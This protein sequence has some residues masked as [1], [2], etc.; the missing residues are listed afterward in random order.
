MIFFFLR[1]HIKFFSK[2]YQVVIFT[3][4]NDTND[5]LKFLPSKVK[6]VDIPFRRKINLFYDLFS[7]IKL[8]SNVYQNEFDIIYSISPKA[9]FLSMVAGKMVGVPIRINNFTGQQ[10]VIK[11][12]FQRQI[13]K[14]VDSATAKLATLNL[15]DGKS[16]QQFLIKNNIINKINSKVIKHGSICGVNLKQFLPNKKH[17]DLTRKKLGIPKKDIVFIYLGRVNKDKG[18]DKIA[19]AITNL[20]KQKFSVSL[21][22]VGP[23]EDPVLDGVAKIFNCYKDCLNVVPFTS[24]PE[25]Y[26]Q[27]SDVFCTLSNKEGFGNSI[28]E[29]GACGLPSIGSNIY[30]LKDSILHNKTG[31]LVDRSDQKKINYYFKKIVKNKNNMIKMGMNAKLRTIKYFDQDIIS[32]ELMETIKDL[33]NKI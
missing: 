3:K 12:G 5:V 6:V 8:T 25:I 24:K 22:I 26:L 20:L 2:N 29:A 21:L 14:F 11:K 10:W 32:K 17:K 13:I 28:I 18:I 16:Q 4:K 31:Y 33:E 27:A 19:I 7:L 15:V 30:G 9:G 23:Q 1:N